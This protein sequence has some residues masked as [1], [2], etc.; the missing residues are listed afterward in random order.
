MIAESGGAIGEVVKKPYHRT[1]PQLI[2]MFWFVRETL[3]R[4]RKLPSDLRVANILHGSS[5]TCQ[6]QKKKRNGK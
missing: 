2:L 6:I 5:N 1:T 4:H 3:N